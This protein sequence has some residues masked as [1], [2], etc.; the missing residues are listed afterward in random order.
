LNT[1][2]PKF[3]EGFR[4]FIFNID[5]PYNNGSDELIYKDKFQH[6]SWLTM[7][8]NRLSLAKDF[9]RKEGGIFLS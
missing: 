5:P 4:Q 3:K 9:L 6:S 8:E 1:I 7:I 2:L